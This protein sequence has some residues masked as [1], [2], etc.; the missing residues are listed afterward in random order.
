MFILSD[1]P[2]SIR[3]LVCLRDEKDSVGGKGALKVV[4][5]R[6]VDVGRLIKREE[7]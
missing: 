1:F 6:E 2:V 7:G 3:T 5:G 4:L